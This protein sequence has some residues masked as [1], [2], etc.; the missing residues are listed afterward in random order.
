MLHRKTISRGR[1]DRTRIHLRPPICRRVTQNAVRR[2]IIVCFGYRRAEVLLAAATTGSVGLMALI[3]RACIIYT[4]D[5]KNA[6]RQS[7]YGLCAFRGHSES[8]LA[9]N[10]WPNRSFSGCEVCWWVVVGR[11]VPEW[12]VKADAIHLTCGTVDIHCAKESSP[13]PP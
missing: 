5:G 13:Q 1:L 2:A 10:L 4:A 9:D 8:Q 6:T 11:T 7:L 3:A 12:T